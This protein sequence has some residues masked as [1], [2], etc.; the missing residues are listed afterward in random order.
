MGVLFGIALLSGVLLNCIFSGFD[1]LNIILAGISLVVLA[2]NL[3]FTKGLFAKKVKKISFTVISLLF[4][5]GLCFIIIL[6]LVLSNA[7]QQSNTFAAKIGAASASIDDKK[8]DKAERNL[9][10]LEKDFPGDADIYLNFAALYIKNGNLEQARRY[11]DAAYKQRPF[12]T[13]VL[14]NY[15]LVFYIQ[16]DYINAISCFEQ[17]C[18]INPYMVEARV[19]AGLS[20]YKQRYLR[21][22]IYHFE[23]ASV[24]DPQ[25]SDIYYFLGLSHY[26]LCLYP[27]AKDLFNTALEANPSKELKQEI[28]KKLNAMKEFEFK[29]VE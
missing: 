19:Y 1:A 21:K 6:V 27:P 24:L 18:A 22:A 28:E 5:I 9:K 23:N 11:I 2:F 15:G 16:K 13:N 3:P 26:D 7:I 8:Y 25:N 10:Q 29:E 20:C 12:D 4:N 14:Y 17:V